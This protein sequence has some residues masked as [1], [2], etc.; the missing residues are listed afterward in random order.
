MNETTMRDIVDVVFAQLRL[1]FGAQWDRMWADGVETP[2]GRDRGVELTKEH[3][4]RELAI[5]DQYRYRLR[6]ALGEAK[7]MARPPNLGEFRA[8]CG[9]APPDKQPALPPPERVRNPTAVDDIRRTINARPK[10]HPLSW[11]RDPKSK[12]AMGFVVAGARAGDERLRALLRK[13]CIDEHP[14]L[15]HAAIQ[16]YLH[17]NEREHVDND[18]SATEGER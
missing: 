2:D 12:V 6:Y 4:V 13:H 1:T 11:A 18:L 17:D 9:M 5:Y 16:W 14:M 10:P 7:R 3:W 8:L 15:T